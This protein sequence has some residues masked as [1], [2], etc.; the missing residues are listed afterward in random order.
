MKTA[1]AA[2]LLLLAGNQFYLAELYTITLSS[3]VV[4]RY[5]DADGSIIYGGNTYTCN[6][7]LMS[8]DKLKIVV[9]VQADTVA[10]TMKAAPA[11]L[12]N[13]IPFPQFAANGGFDGALVQIDR[14]YMAT[15]GDTSAGVVN[16][17]SGMVIEVSPSRTE[18]VLHA[19]SNLQ[20]LNIAMPRNLYTPG[21][22]HSIYDSECGAV[23]ASFGSASSFSSGTTSVINCGLI[24]A[25]KWFDNGTITFSSG[26][27][28]GAQRTVKSYTVGVLILALPLATTP[29]AG[30]TFTAYAGCNKS[31]TDC[32]NKFNRLVSFRGFPF[33][34]IAESSI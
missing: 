19:G 27:N 6:A 23:K 34:P 17:F 29:T 26:A 1:S 7:P 16:M 22:T 21:C 5:T 2:T 31:Q 14:C 18:V 3:G 20:L 33:V 12:I 11:N 25:A 30:D 4:L 13:G 28:A 10:I 9:G 15:Y 32:V 8:R 24:Q